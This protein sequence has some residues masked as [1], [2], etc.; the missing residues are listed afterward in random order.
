MLNFLTWDMDP[1]I[2]SIGSLEIRYYGLLWASSFWLGYLL[3]KKMYLKEGI[4]EALLDPLLYAVLIG[5]VLGARLGHVFFYDFDWYFTVNNVEEKSHML[6]VLNIREGGL[7]SHGGAIGVIIGIW[8]Y[9]KFKIKRSMLWVLDR[10][11]IAGALAGAFIR[12][13]NFF[14]S[15]IVGVPTEKPWGI[16]FTY[17]GENFARHPAQL[18]E[19][20][21]YTV[22]LVLLLFLYKKKK[23]V[24]QEGKMFGLFLMVVFTAR[25]FIEFI[26]NSQH[27]IESYFG[28][29]LSTGQLLSIP[30]VLIGAFFMVR[31]STKMDH[32]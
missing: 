10:M 1:A 31:K 17:L 16:V 8:W 30:F 23:L 6:S 15:E 7:A 20:L 27:G 19:A 32:Q 26:K 3:I 29:V 13:G 11:V 22:V 9:S 18:Y 4:K 12:V 5:A 28:D 2:F 24:A 14:N 25:F 21:A